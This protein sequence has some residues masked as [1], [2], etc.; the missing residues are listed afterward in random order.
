MVKQRVPQGPDI[1]RLAPTFALIIR[2]AT[3]LRR[4]HSERVFCLFLDN[5]FLNINVSHALL[6]LD[7]C[8]IGTTRKNASGIPS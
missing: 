8:Y 3:R 7:I 1:I 4:I 5:L 6:A 2:L